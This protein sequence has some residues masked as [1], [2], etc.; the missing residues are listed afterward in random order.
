MRIQDIVHTAVESIGLEESAETAWQ[1]MDANRM[2]H[3]V[4]LDRRQIVEVVSDRDLGGG[5]AGVSARQGK[6]VSDVMTLKPVTVGP[7]T[8]IRDHHRSTR[9]G[10]TRGGTVGRDGQALDAQASG[11]APPKEPSL[12]RS[13]P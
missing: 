9:V 1:R 4:V 5:E 10:R 3:L 12:K 11:A 8:T 7:T 2:H 13:S 6:A